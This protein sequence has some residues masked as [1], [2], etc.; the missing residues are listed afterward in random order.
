[1]IVNQSPGTKR[2]AKLPDGRTVSTDG[3]IAVVSEVG[4]AVAGGTFAECGVF[5]AEQRTAAGAIRAQGRDDQGGWFEIDT[6]SP[7]INWE[8]GRTL[9]IAHG[10]G[11]AR[12]WTIT[13]ALRQQAGRIRVR[14]E[15]EPG[16]RIEPASGE[17]VYYQYP[18]T[19]H[20]GPHQARVCNVARSTD[21]NTGDQQVYDTLGNRRR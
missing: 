13:E 1:L 8:S 19:R 11:T 10:D 3:L 21:R 5:R 9:V 12:A 16:F 20:P 6:D 18:Q 4:V 15:E 7:S 2:A 14:V 17:A